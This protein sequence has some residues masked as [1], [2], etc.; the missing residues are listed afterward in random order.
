MEEFSA[1]VQNFAILLEF[2]CLCRILQNFIKGNLPIISSD[3][4]AYDSWYPELF[5]IYQVTAETGKFAA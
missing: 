3:T 2:L 1:E 4:M 5:V